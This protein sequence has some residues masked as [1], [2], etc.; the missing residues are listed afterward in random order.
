MAKDLREGQIR[1]KT[2]TIREY[3]RMP[4]GVMQA[5]GGIFLFPAI[6]S[7]FWSCQASGSIL[8]FAA[9]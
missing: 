7:G 6:A 3:I 4:S 8:F 1:A 9:S 5:P 2:V